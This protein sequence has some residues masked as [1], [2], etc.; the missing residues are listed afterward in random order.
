[1]HYL[2]AAFIAYT[3]GL[4]W[5]YYLSLIWIFESRRGRAAELSMVIA[6]AV[7]GVLLTELLLWAFVANAGMDPIPAKII[8]LWIVLIWNFGMRKAYVFH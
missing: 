7:G 4:I 8:V 2:E 3:F 6:I 5:N 1:M